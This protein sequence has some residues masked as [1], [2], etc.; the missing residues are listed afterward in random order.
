MSDKD[1]EKWNR[2]YLEKPTLLEERPPSEMLVF[3]L[4]L[5]EGNC[6]LDLACGSGRHTR[7]LTEKGFC[8]DAVDISSIALDQLSKTLDSKRVTLIEVDL[9]SF[10]PQEGRYDLAVMTNYLDRK[11][12]ARTAESLKSGALFFIETYMEHPENEKKDSNPDF[13]LKAGEL[14]TLFDSRFTEIAYEEFWNES[15]ELYK[16]RKQA[17][18]VQKK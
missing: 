3:H 12:I 8:V 4:H 2:K 7:F 5:V 10:T 9:D 11:L 13:L 6:A 15:Y 16:M 17:I 18:F 1:R 14:K